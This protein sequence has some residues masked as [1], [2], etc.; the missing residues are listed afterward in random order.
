MPLTRERRTKNR[1]AETN[2]HGNV[3]AK[4]I[5]TAHLAHGG[6][7][8]YNRA[9]T[10]EMLKQVREYSKIEQKRD[11]ENAKREVAQMLARAAME[12]QEEQAIHD[13]FE[14][15]EEMLEEFLTGRDSQTKKQL[16]G[17]PLV[18]KGAELEGKLYEL[19]RFIERTRRIKEKYDEHRKQVLDMF[20]QTAMKIKKIDFVKVK[21]L[22]EIFSKSLNLSGPER[23]WLELRLISSNRN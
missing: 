1:K 15:I 3:S 16:V 5:R 20:I 10:E 6:V 8:L 9:A 19:F 18:K 11:F 2:F 14:E 12:E 21:N 22:I 7:A 23:N 4:F 13:V 17:V